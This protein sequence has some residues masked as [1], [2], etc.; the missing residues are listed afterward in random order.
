MG[1]VNPDVGVVMVV[2]VHD[3][4][5]VPEAVVTVV[6]RIPVGMIAVIVVP[7]VGAPGMPVRRPVSPVPSRAPYV[8]VGKVN[9][10]DQR[11]G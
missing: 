5:S 7:V 10:A 3:P 9:E 2:I 8:V 4:G 6:V 11:P 1:A